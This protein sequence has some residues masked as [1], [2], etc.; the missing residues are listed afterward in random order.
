MKRRDKGVGPNDGGDRPRKQTPGQI[1]KAIMAEPGIPARFLALEAIQDT[2][3]HA[4]PTDRIG[5]LA[6]SYK[7]AGRERRLAHEI[8]AGSIK[9]R[10]SLDLLIERIGKCRCKSIEPRLLNILRQGAYRL[11][12]LEHVPVFAAVDLSGKLARLYGGERQ[13][14]FVNAVL[15]NIQR[16][17]VDRDAVLAPGDEEFILPKTIARG[18]RFN[19]RILPPVAEAAEHLA[20]A[21]SLPRFLV[22]RWLTRF[23]FDRTRQ[24]AAAANARPIT[25]ARPN[26]L[27]LGSP[28]QPTEAGQKLARRLADEGCQVHLTGDRGAVEIVEG[29]PL[30]E[31]PAFA[32]GLFQIQDTTAQEI[33]W[34]LEPKPDETILDLCAGLG[35]KT[36]QLAELTGDRAAIVA[37]DRTGGKLDKLK[38][39]ASR[40]G[41]NSIGVEPIERILSVEYDGRFDAVLVDVPCSN[42]G[43]LSCRPEVRWRLKETDI[44]VLAQVA[45]ELLATAL[46]LVKPSGRI[47]YSTCS[48]ELEENARAVQ[49]FLNAAKGWRLAADD[50]RLPQAD[51]QSGRAIHDG[52]YWAIL[53]RDA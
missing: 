45:G 17:T 9:R 30:A 42:T 27:K 1:R 8:L 31:L 18:V 29:P 53:R 43:V 26:F 14:A 16:A 48:I 19:R 6:E 32:E 4:L 49:R 13:V 12:F 37:T 22:K 20:A 38:L 7:V 5:V 39:N 23:D 50:E 35:T 25:V 24:I 10:A 36:T 15:R 47:G 51:P 40:L 46:R 44:A 34:R 33:A 52:G 11:V 28:H 3:L 41:I 21:Y 2:T